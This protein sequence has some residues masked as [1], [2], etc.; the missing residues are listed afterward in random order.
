MNRTVYYIQGY[1]KIH[2]SRKCALASVRYCIDEDVRTILIPLNEYSIT[3][4][5]RGSL[6][7]P[8]VC[9]RCWHCDEDKAV[10]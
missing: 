2:R 4:Y 5:V 10:K 8:R 6:Y 1:N 9:L 7:S 3:D